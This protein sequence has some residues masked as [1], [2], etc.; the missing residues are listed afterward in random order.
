MIQA[1]CIHFFLLL[2]LREFKQY[3]T[4]SCGCKDIFVDQVAFNQNLRVEQ[5][6]VLFLFRLIDILQCQLECASYSEYDE[7]KMIKMNK[8]KQNEN[9]KP[10]S[11]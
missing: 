1:K 5:R 11:S 4:L 2:L 6:S 7:K 10:K 3:C 9:Q 8:T